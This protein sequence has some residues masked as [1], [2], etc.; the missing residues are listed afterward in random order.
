MRLLFLAPRV[1][2]PADT[3]G[4]IRTV[5]ILKQMTK[6]AQIHLACLSF[7]KNDP[8]YAK[9]LKK[10]GIAV[11]LI[12]AEEPGM[13]PKAAG[14]MLNPI[15]CSIAKYYSKSMERVLKSL[16]QTYPFDAVHVDH[17]HMAHYSHCFNNR[18]CILDEHNVEYKILE[19]CAKA[20]KTLLKK[21]IYAAQANKM[22]NF[23][24]RQI[25]LCSRYLAVSDDDLRLLDELAGTQRKGRGHVIPN[26]VD[27]DF[28][29]SSNAPFTGSEDALAFTG[30]M[31][32]IPN[33]DAVV[34]FCREVLPLIWEQ[35]PNVKFYIVGKNPSAT[36]K[37]LAQKDPRIVV[38][39][40]VD[41]VRTY[42]QLAKIFV[43][44]IRIGG[45]TRLKILEAMSMRKAVVSTTV[46]AEGI[47]C[48][49]DVDI[50]LGD[51][52]QAFAQQV[53]VLLKDQ[54]K[55]E[56]LGTAARK[57]VLEKYDWRIIGKKLDQIYED[58]TNAR[59][60]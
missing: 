26:G 29:Q 10:L 23:E 2:W 1:P 34:F 6:F 46:G 5:N 38:T 25:R 52:P 41:D 27:V 32:W 60:Q 3:G 19:R 35:N 22:K 31:D 4:K 8:E 16:Q 49:K 36:V 12:P 28:F 55:R 33:D 53:I 54:R 43:V 56:A 51:T 42:I 50:V 20:E 44:P 9:E 30:S 47:A 11:T 37:E 40:R 24:T 39:G 48:T 21:I 15:P 13:I 14:I 7:E 17:V 58:I 18:P 45:G 59:Q 57:L